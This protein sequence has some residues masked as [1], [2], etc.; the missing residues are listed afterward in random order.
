LLRSEE[1]LD[2]ADVTAFSDAVASTFCRLRQH[3]EVIQLFAQGTCHFEVP[4]SF[5]P[6]EASGVVVR[7]RIDCLVVSP[8]GSM[9][10]VEF[11]TG[12]PRPEHQSQ[13]NAYRAALAAAL[14]GRRIDVR[15][16]Y[17]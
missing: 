2:V 17:P 1:L 14:P 11:K 5:Q 16:L 15:V 7:G 3:E 13:V 9:T 6:P 10:I 12:R 4:F 8:D